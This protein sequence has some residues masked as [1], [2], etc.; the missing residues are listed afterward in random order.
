MCT[1]RH[2]IINDARLCTGSRA[3]LNTY[4]Q[5]IHSAVTLLCRK[6]PLTS[7][8]LSTLPVSSL[9]PK[10]RSLSIVSTIPSSPLCFI[11]GWPIHATYYCTL[12]HPSTSLSQEH[13]RLFVVLFPESFATFSLSEHCTMYYRPGLDDHGLPHDPFK[14]RAISCM[15]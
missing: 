12:S 1:T 9:C 14:V 8:L 13:I 5:C 10:Q 6:A 7:E 11:I 4:A 3:N 15:T 2:K